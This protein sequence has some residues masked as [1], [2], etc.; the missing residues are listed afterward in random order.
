LGY[1]FCIPCIT[2]FFFFIELAIFVVDG[3]SF[4]S[5]DDIGPTSGQD[6]GYGF[7]KSHQKFLITQNIA[8]LIRYALAWVAL[9]SFWR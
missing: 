3:L 5:G 6:R 2:N 4:L 7:E 1:I 8:I 9:E